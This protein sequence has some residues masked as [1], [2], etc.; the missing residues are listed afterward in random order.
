MSE[1]DGQR[2]RETDRQ[3]ERQTEREKDTHTNTFSSWEQGL[4][5]MGMYLATRVDMANVR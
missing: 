5:Y 4:P 1:T 2:E 3:T